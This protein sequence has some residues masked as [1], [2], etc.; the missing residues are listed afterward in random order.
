MEWD[1]SANRGE[2]YDPNEY[3]RYPRGAWV[4]AIGGGMAFM[5][6]IAALV[7]ALVRN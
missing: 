5:L 4:A 7:A 1:R 6:T 2:S 3:P